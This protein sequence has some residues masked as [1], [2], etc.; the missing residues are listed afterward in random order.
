MGYKD[1]DIPQ[2]LLR[3]TSSATVFAP[4]VERST[5][6]KVAFVSTFF[7]RHSV[8]RL[9]GDVMLHLDRSIFDIHLIIPLVRVYSRLLT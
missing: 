9:L 7:F 1:W 5:R 3:I 2:A 6:I 4:F 8:G